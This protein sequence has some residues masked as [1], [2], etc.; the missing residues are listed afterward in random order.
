[1]DNAPN[2]SRRKA[3]QFLGAA[4]MLPLGG[5]L[6]GST[7]LSACGSGTYTAPPAQYLATTFTASAVP[8]LATP[9]AM[10]TTTVTSLLNVQYDDKTTQAYKLAY[11]PFFMTGDMVADGKGG[12][13]LAGGYVDIKNQPILDASV[14]GKVRQFYSD[15]PDGTSLLALDNPTVSGL[16]GKAVFAVVQF[17][18]TTRDQANVSAYGLLPSPIAILTLDQD[19]AT[20]TRSTRR[21]C[22]A[23]GSLAAPACRRGTPTCRAKSTS[24]MRSPPPTPSWPASARTCSATPPPPTLTTTATCRK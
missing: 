5:T 16:K 20:G 7:L 8:T 15:S 13:I 10:A 6:L 11:Q 9:A 23:C 3:L 14:A 1:M 22:T 2:L 19:Q 18:Y 4:P 24:R 12:T 21:P 17:E